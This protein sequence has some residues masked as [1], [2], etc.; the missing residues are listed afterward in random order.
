M[1]FD[2]MV[3]G[4]VAVSSTISLQAGKLKKSINR[5]QMRSL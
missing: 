2:G 4:A 1:S 3:T 5:K